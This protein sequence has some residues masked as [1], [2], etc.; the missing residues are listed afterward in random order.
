MPAKEMFIAMNGQGSLFDQGGANTV[1]SFVFFVPDGAW[2]Q[3]DLL[4]RSAQV[5]IANPVD[6]HAIAIGQDHREARASDLLIEAIHFNSGDVQKV[7][8]ALLVFAQTNLFEYLGLMRMNGI[9]AIV[10][11]ATDPGPGNT[12]FR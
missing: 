4:E 10:V 8:Q 3:T 1:G 6:D 7:I 9:K 2:P 12:G 5:G 11:D